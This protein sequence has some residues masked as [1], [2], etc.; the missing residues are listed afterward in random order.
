VCDGTD[1]GTV[2]DEKCKIGMTGPGGGLIFFVDYNDQYARYDYLE[3][4]PT[5]GVFAS[6]TSTGVWATTN[7]ACGASSNA[8]CQTNSIYTETGAALA[9]IKGL[10]RGLFGGQAATEAIIAKHSLVALNLYAAGVADSYTAPSFNG[11]TKSDYYLPTK[12]EGELMQKN[13]NNVGVGGFMDGE[14]W[15]SSESDA[16]FAWRQGFLSGRQGNVGKSTTIY[17]RPVRRF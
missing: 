5:D 3:A 15:S 14:Y 9:T 10:H 13:L 7:P 4:A 8:S 6:G 17:V 16:G 12:D 11:V 2:A 1:A